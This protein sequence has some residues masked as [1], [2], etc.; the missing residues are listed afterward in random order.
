MNFTPK[1]IAIVA[2]CV[3][4]GIVVFAIIGNMLNLGGIS[5]PIGAGLGAVVGFLAASR[6]QSNQ[7]QK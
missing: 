4:L 1:F 5:A 7:A 2:V 6:N 3:V